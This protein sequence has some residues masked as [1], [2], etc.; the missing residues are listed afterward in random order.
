M[1]AVICCNREQRSDSTTIQRL[2]AREHAGTP[3]FRE[4]GTGHTAICHRII[5]NNSP[6]WQRTESTA[7]DA[8]GTLPPLKGPHVEMAY[9]RGVVRSFSNV[10]AALR[11]RVPP[12]TGRTHVVGAG[13]CTAMR[14]MQHARAW[15]SHV[16]SH[17]HTCSGGPMRGGRVRHLHSS[18]MLAARPMSWRDSHRNIPDDTGSLGDGSGGGDEASPAKLDEVVT[19]LMEEEPAVFQTRTPA[20]LWRRTLAGLQD[21]AVA[22]AS[23]AVV[24]LPPFFLEAVSADAAAMLLVVGATAVWSVRDCCTSEGNRSWGKRTWGLEL[25][26]W[27]G[28]LPSRTACF[29][30]NVYWWLLPG[31]L[32]SP[33]RYRSV[34]AVWL[35]QVAH[36]WR[37]LACQI[38]EDVAFLAAAV[39]ASALLLTFDRRKLGDWTIGTTVVVQGE[40]RATRLQ[41]AQDLQEISKLEALVEEL[42]EKQKQDMADLANA[43]QP[44]R[45]MP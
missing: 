33:V 23:G 26:L 7:G 17:A 42:T 40:D 34:R 31:A 24:A 43:Q 1:H 22:L 29:F 25:V 12:T 21:L 19:R 10:C 8:V 38:A 39:D 13:A 27:D 11:A 44:D 9:P 16:L 30:R 20:P 2:Q 14:D 28:D 3:Q 37:R 36:V 6:S 15:A 41:M 4:T 32:V 35:R 18:T 5:N 45:K